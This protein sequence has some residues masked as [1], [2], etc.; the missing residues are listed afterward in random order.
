MRAALRLAAFCLLIP[1]TQLEA[2]ESSCI[3][4]HGDE[5]FFDEEGVQLVA[6]FA[7]GVHAAVE[8]SCHDCHGGNPDPAHAEDL[9]LSMD[10]EWRAAPYVGA[11]APAEVS[12]FCG[13]CHSNPEFMRRYSP[14]ARIDQEQEYL[15]SQHGLSLAAGD[16]AVATCTSC[17]GAHGIRRVDDPEASVYP[18]RI[19]ETCSGCHSDAAL[20]AER[21]TPDG[22]P[23]AVDQYGRWRSSVHA[24]ALLDRS[25]LSAPTCNDCH[26]N[27]GA[28][29]PGLDSIAFVCGQCHPREADLFRNSSKQAGFDEHAAYLEDAGDEGCA[30][31]HDESEPAYSVTHAHALTECASCHRNHAVVRPSLA[32]FDPLPAEPCS[33]CHALPGQNMEDSD[34]VR[35]NFETAREELLEEIEVLGLTGERRFDYLVDRLLQLPAHRV[36][37]ERGGELR[38]EFAE[39]FRRFRIGRTRYA[40]TGENGEEILE[41]IVRCGDCHAAE[42]LLADAP[43][44]LETATALTEASRE[45][46]TKTATAERRFLEARRGGIET[47]HVLVDIEAAIDAQI[48]LAVLVH[49]FSA[50]PEGAFMVRQEEGIAAANTAL[51]GA[52]HAIEELGYRRRGLAVSLVFV[53]LLLI[54]L[55]IKI[56][57]LGTSAD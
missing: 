28:A 42:P 29:P 3:T 30:A 38:P 48:G 47:R 44:G 33:F 43:V 35:R 56:R 2:Q 23:L 57:Q 45:L 24:E 50:D 7:D 27:H 52:G 32:M 18:T 25:D 55:A 39:L 1:A 49:T 41:R 14:D 46:T 15:T 26:G 9:D 20:M 12:A 11:P 54:A 51:E 4:C 17:H 10:P 6:D 13:R 37:G 19:A 34:A 8:L 40:Y 5:G 21:T 22:R 53:S 16:D 31:C 36:R